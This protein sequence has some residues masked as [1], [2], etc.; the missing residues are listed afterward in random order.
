MQV[1]SQGWKDPLEDG[2]ATYSSILAWR[3]HGQRSLTGYT[4]WGCTELGTTKVTQQQQQQQQQ[5]QGFS[6]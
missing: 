1:Q 2:M 6:K 3:I 4:P 5:Q